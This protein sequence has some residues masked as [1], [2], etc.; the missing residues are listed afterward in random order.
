[1]LG[2]VEIY[3]QSFHTWLGCT[4]KCH[5]SFKFAD[6]RVECEL[7]HY[8]ENRGE[9]GGTDQLR[10]LLKVIYS[11]HLIFICRKSAF[12]MADE[13]VTFKIM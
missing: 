5:Q 2:E 8:V 3:H 4:F 6:D 13:V 12:A 9:Y 10:L 1:M 11:T 7:N